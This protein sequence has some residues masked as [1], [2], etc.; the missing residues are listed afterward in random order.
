MYMPVYDQVHEL[1]RVLDELARTELPCDELLLVDN[2]STDGSE[3][4]VRASGWP[5][6]RVERNRGCGLSNM[7]ALD[8]ALARGFDAFGT[9]ASNGKMLPAEMHRIVEPLARGAA[10]Y[11]TGSRFLAGGDSPNLP[12]FRRSAI[13]LVNRFARLATGASLTDATCGYRAYTLELVRRAEFDWHAPWLY[14]YAMEYYLYAK[15]LLAPGLRC[16][17]VP[18]TMRYPANP[19]RASKIRPGRHWY[20]MLKPWVVARLDGRGLGPAVRGTLGD[21]SSAAKGGR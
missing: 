21:P 5:H 12:A 4:L 16:I 18:I 13:P 3:R 2:G 17:E 19:K 1:P 10:D 14:G 8:W 11:V 7:L 6:L 15:A 9:M 20:Q